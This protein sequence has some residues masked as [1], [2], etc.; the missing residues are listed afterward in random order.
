MALPM[1]REAPVTKAVFQFSSS[2]MM[3]SCQDGIDGHFLIVDRRIVICHPK[4][5]L[6]EKPK[7][8]G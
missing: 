5:K 8:G 1:P 4:V 7:P 2:V 6:G 3:V